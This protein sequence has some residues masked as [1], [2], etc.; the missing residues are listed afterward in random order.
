MTKYVLSALLI[1]SLS[2]N[3]Y[4]YFRSA[5]WE[6]AWLQQFVTTSEVEE[7]LKG[8]SPNLSY[9]DVAALLKGASPVEA[10]APLQAGVEKKALKYGG[11]TFYF[12]DGVYAGSKADLPGH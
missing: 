12:K 7:L 8:A 9:D 1:I 3:A 5:K 2:L 10:G 4:F 11:T 6:E